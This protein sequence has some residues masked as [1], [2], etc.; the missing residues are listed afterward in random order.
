MNIRHTTYEDLPRVMEIYAYALQPQGRHFARSA[1]LVMFGHAR[2][3]RKSP[4]QPMS[5]A[6]RQKSYCQL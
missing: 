3:S 1:S 5:A 6:R 2:R 4:L